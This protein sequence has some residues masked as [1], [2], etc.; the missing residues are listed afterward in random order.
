VEEVKQAKGLARPWT[1]GAKKTLFCIDHWQPV[2]KAWQKMYV[3]QQLA[4]AASDSMNGTLSE[5][6]RKGEL[7]VVYAALRVV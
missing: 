6:H 2:N 1:P 5:G 3:L 4:P 7:T